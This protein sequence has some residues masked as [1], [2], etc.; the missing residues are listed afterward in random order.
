[1]ADFDRLS[2][3]G[4]HLLISLFNKRISDVLL[5]NSSPIKRKKIKNNVRF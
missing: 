5:N 4:F 2:F 1:M 3:N